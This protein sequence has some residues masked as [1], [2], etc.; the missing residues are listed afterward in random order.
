MREGLKREMVR[1]I[2]SFRKKIGLGINDRINIYYQTD[3]EIL[4][5]VF[6][7]KILKQELIKDTLS[8]KID[9]TDNEKGEWEKLIIDEG[10][11]NFKIEKNN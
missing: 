4:K 1:F 11:I 3:S 5:K 8:L 6:S 10:E 7:N 2:N 9:E